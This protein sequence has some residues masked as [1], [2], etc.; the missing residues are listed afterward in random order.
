MTFYP[1]IAGINIGD[2]DWLWSP[3]IQITF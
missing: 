1:F 3:K 2:L